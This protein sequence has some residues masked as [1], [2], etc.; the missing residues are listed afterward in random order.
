M[1]QSLIPAP[2]GNCHNRSTMAARILVVEDEPELNALLVEQLGREGYDVRSA[3]DGLEAVAAFEA[4]S[5]D[6][7]VLDWMLPKLDGL[8]RAQARCA[9]TRWCRC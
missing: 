5:F 1:S 6:L 2:G 3:F 4:G 7:V 9:S 8:R